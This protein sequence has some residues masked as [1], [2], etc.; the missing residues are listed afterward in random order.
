MCA[1]IVGVGRGFYIRP[2]PRQGDWVIFHPSETCN[3]WCRFVACF[4]RGFLMRAF[5][6]KGRVVQRLESYLLSLFYVIS[7]NELLMS[8]TALTHYL[9]VLQE[10]VKFEC[11]AR[12]Y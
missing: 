10:M 7:A 12:W 4:G 5:L 3:R 11:L 6:M 8:L 1:I 9:I 2:S